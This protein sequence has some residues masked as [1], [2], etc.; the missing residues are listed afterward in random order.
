MCVHVEGG[1]TTHRLCWWDLCFDQVLFPMF[2]MSNLKTFSK[3]VLCTLRCA[4]APTALPLSLT[5][6]Q[7]LFLLLLWAHLKFAAGHS[8][9]S[10]SASSSPWCGFVML[11]AL[12]CCSLA[13]WQL[14]CLYFMV[15]SN[16]PAC[17][18]GVCVLWCA[19]KYLVLINFYK[20]SLWHF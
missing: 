1:Y 4:S 20:Y 15:I 17:V 16:V 2:F 5:P 6:P 14:F 11:F 10:S 19:R 13:S 9:C 3:Y 12:C 18:C 8:T 7:L